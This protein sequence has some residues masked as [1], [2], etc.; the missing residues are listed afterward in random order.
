MD[1]ALF[2]GKLIDAYENGNLSPKAKAQLKPYLDNETVRGYRS[3]EPLFNGV[4]AAREQLIRE[5][6]CRVLSEKL[7]QQGR[8][9][10][11]GRTGLMNQQQQEQQ[12]TD[13]ASAERQQK[14]I[15]DHDNEIV[16][17]EQA[18]AAAAA[19]TVTAQKEATA[20]AAAAKLAEDAVVA[21]QNAEKAYNYLGY[22]KAWAAIKAGFQEAPLGQIGFA[23]PVKLVNDLLEGEEKQQVEK[24]KTQGT[25]IKGDMGTDAAGNDNLEKLQSQAEAATSEAVRGKQRRENSLLSNVDLALSGFSAMNVHKGS[26]FGSAQ[27][28]V[29][30]Y[31]MFKQN[32]GLWYELKNATYSFDSSSEDVVI[33]VVNKLCNRLVDD[34]T[35][36]LARI[37]EAD[38]EMHATVELRAAKLGL[39]ITNLQDHSNLGIVN[40]IKMRID[41][42]NEWNRKSNFEKVTNVIDS[43][44]ELVNKTTN[45]AVSCTALG[46]AAKAGII[47]FKNG[48]DQIKN[49]YGQSD[50]DDAA[51]VAAAANLNKRQESMEKLKAAT[52]KTM[53]IALNG[54][55][56]EEGEKILGIN[57]MKKEVAE[58][59]EWIVLAETN[60]KNLQDDIDNLNSD[61]EDKAVS[62]EV[63]DGGKVRVIQKNTESTPQSE[64]E[65]NKVLKEM[66]DLLTA[67]K[68]AINHQ[69]E[70]QKQIARKLISAEQIYHDNSKDYQKISNSLDDIKIKNIQA[71][72][73]IGSGISNA[74]KKKELENLISTLGDSQKKAMQIN[75]TSPVTSV[76]HAG[77][78]GR[79]VTA[80]PTQSP[81]QGQGQAPAVVPASKP[82]PFGLL[83]GGPMDSEDNPINK[84][85]N[86]YYDEKDELLQKNM[87]TM[88]QNIIDISTLQFENISENSF[89]ENCLVGGTIMEI[90]YYNMKELGP[91]SLLEIFGISRET[92]LQVMN[93]NDNKIN[94]GLSGAQQVESS[95][96]LSKKQRQKRNKAIKEISM[97]GSIDEI[98]SYVESLPDYMKADQTLQD[99]VEQHKSDINDGFTVVGRKGGKTRKKKNKNRRSRKKSNKRKKRSRRKKRKN[100]TKKN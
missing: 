88:K 66:E 35:D 42:C 10:Q 91:L 94:Q 64:D 73:I 80:A 40:N 100:K 69:K 72:S 50:L 21:A 59:E 46:A 65:K 98:D 9:Y 25:A 12:A 56:D 24:I 93:Y 15:A 39:Q 96:S 3:T 81:T 84:D 29:T 41:K 82:G 32:Q 4:Y 67:S 76:L 34:F 13:E 85:S 86:I 45:L 6:A 62:F 30:F 78:V 20:A 26:V 49:V 16:K 36:V 71:A 27:T 75:T 18:K 17:R 99:A 57:D 38:D 14:A 8:T 52:K 68:M 23:Y 95:Q 1:I 19:A 87:V 33:T 43:G 47:G 48:L 51:A 7:I 11:H 74:T 55:D 54:S 61:D 37:K 28:A 89:E 60:I 22:K 92:C 2:F 90:L 79:T 53:D 70:K 97:L 5:D 63:L 77:L 83:G 58:V 44:T 31:Y